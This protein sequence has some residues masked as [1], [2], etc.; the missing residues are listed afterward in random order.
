[1]IIPSGVSNS[2]V[3]LLETRLNFTNVKSFKDVCSLSD[4][5]KLYGTV[6]IYSKFT[7]SKDVKYLLVGE[8]YNI[9]DIPRYLLH[10]FKI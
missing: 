1:M 7:A 10:L 8:E 3:V 5:F 6:K 9:L 2:D 4:I